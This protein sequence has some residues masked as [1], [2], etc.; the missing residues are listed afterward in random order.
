MTKVEYH[1]V[2]NR[3]QVSAISHGIIAMEQSITI[4]D[5]KHE[6][7]LVGKEQYFK[8]LNSETK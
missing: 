1:I 3:Q 2:M 8:M 7:V 6:L 4:G 5:K